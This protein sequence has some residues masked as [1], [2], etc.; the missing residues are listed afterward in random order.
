MFKTKY[1]IKKEE[2][3]TG[4]IQY[5]PQKRFLFIWI[6]IFNYNRDWGSFIYPKFAKLEDCEE[7]IYNLDV[8]FSIHKPLQPIK[9][10]YLEIQ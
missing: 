2:Y 6:D 7:Y 10:E 1:R 4:N 8:K 3:L 5:I 9:V